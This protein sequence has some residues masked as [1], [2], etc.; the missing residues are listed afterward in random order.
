MDEGQDG[1]LDLLGL[2]TVLGTNLASITYWLSRQGLIGTAG[3]FPAA[4]LDVSPPGPLGQAAQE[5]LLVGP[6]C[7][8]LPA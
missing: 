6:G 1:S 7:R 4:S 2:Y 5:S 3:Y 8:Q